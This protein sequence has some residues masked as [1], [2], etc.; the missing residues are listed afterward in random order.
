MEQTTKQP[1]GKVK[2]NFV[3]ILP[4]DAR[5]A[6]M[7]AEER[8]ANN[9]LPVYRG[10][11]SAPETPDDIHEYAVWDY[12]DDAGNIFYAGP[13]QPLCTRATVE[14]HLAAKPH[15]VA[16]EMQSRQPGDYTLSPNSIIIRPSKDKVL[17]TSADFAGLSQDEKDLNARRPLYWLKWQR[18]AGAQE[19]RGSLWDKSGRYGPFL[20]GN[21][22]YPLDRQQ[23]AQQQHPEMTTPVVEQDPARKRGG[24][25]MSR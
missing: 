9:K 19:I 2:G 17:K 16:A 6:K 15:D 25:S 10:I 18:E 20:D 22:L 5:Y 23:L 24:R 3:R 21:T 7:S 12:K 1:Q 11:I 8:A 13:V 4:H 14:D